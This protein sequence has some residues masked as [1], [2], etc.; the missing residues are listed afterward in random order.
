MIQLKSFACYIDLIRAFMII[1]TCYLCE[2]ERER[3]ISKSKLQ[4]SFP[5]IHLY[6]YA[7]NY[8]KNI[9]RAFFRIFVCTF[10]CIFLC[11]WVFYL[12][13]RWERKSEGKQSKRE[14]KNEEFFF[15][16]YREFQLM[17]ST[18]DDSSLSSNQNTN[19]FLV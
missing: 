12:H 4:I 8:W 7:C 15:F 18:S 5:T 1:S 16:F 6:K 2:R 14:G 13:M 3:T 19:Q 11:F 17:A 10:Q 9:E